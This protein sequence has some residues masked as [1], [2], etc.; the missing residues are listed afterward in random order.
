M[1]QNY[2]ADVFTAGVIKVVGAGGSQLVMTVG[3]N[4][5]V[6]IQIDANGDGT[7]DKT[8]SST[9]SELEALL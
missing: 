7:F 8:V 1:V 3:S 5:T 6:T 4:N 9:M 2:S